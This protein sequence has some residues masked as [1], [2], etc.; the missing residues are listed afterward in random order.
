MRLKQVLPQFDLADCSFRAKWT[1]ELEFLG[2]LCDNVVL[3]IVWYA[4][5]LAA[6]WAHVWFLACV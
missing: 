3:E 4:E 5:C 6:V 1:E 2:V